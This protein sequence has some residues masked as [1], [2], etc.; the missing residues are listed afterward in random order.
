MDGLGYVHD[1]FYLILEMI[2]EIRPLEL[3]KILLAK[4]TNR[5]IHHPIDMSKLTNSLLDHVADG[6]GISDVSLQ[7]DGLAIAGGD[8]AHH[9]VGTFGASEI[10]YDYRC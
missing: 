1:A 10:I 6:S 2:L 4:V 9:G 3:E 8:R 5:T 7:R